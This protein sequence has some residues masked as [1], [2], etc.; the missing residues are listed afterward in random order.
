MNYLSVS[1]MPNKII[2]DGRNQQESGHLCYKFKVKIGLSYISSEKRT[3][4]LDYHG[5]SEVRK[6][7][8]LS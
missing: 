7:I 4:P 8:H 1:C 6:V 5:R 2:Q 3:E